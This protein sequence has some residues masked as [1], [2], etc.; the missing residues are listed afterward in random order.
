MP[1]LLVG[2]LCASFVFTAA[3]HE[4]V[5]AERPAAIDTAD[6]TTDAKKDRIMGA[7]M[8]VLIGDALG[9]GSH[10]YYDLEEFKGDFGWVSGYSDPKID[11]TSRFTPVH[12]LRYD[13]GVRAGDP[14]PDRTTHHPVARVHCREGHLRS[15]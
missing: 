12:K 14:I 2:V 6:E 9:V 10:W 3:I 4:G 15:T 7:I 1:R 8:G 13:Q 5:A 11:G